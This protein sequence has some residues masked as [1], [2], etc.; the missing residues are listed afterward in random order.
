MRPT[1]DLVAR[2]EARGELA[3]WSIAHADLAFALM[4]LEGPLP[5]PAQRLVDVNRLR[6][7]IRGYL[8]HRRPPHPPPKPRS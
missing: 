7:S 5:D 4:R 2:L 6:P 8:D 1:I 3:E